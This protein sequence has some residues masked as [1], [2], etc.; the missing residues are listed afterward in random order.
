MLNIEHQYVILLLPPELLTQQSTEAVIAS[1]KYLSQ[2]E[3]EIK[4]THKRNT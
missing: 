4:K 3:T 2:A 1:Y